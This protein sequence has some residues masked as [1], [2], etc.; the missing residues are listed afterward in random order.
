MSPS[1]ARIPKSLRRLPGFTT[2]RRFLLERPTNCASKEGLSC[3][4]I[5]SRED[6]QPSY[7][8][9]L[10][11]TAY[12]EVT[13]QLLHKIGFITRMTDAFRILFYWVGD[14]AQFQFFLS[15][16]FCSSPF[17][18]FS[19]FQQIVYHLQMFQQPLGVVC[20][21]KN[22]YYHASCIWPGALPEKK[23]IV[24]SELFSK[25]MLKMISVRLLAVS[26]PPF[27][28]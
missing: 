3:S 26:F 12:N 4:V 23:Q 11:Y 2:R 17:L 1:D 18:S 7:L 28:F 16:I 25:F 19:K 9:N 13:L 22:I 24:L 21:P 27:M 14:D 6:L 20:P 15:W 5:H 8:T 10:S